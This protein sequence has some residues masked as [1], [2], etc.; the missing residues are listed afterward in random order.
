MRYLLL[1]VLAASLAAENAHTPTGDHNGD[2]HLDA[3]N[4]HL[5]ACASHA[6]DGYNQD[7]EKLGKDLAKRLKICRSEAENAGNTDAVIAIDHALDGLPKVDEPVVEAPTPAPAPQPE[8]PNPEP[9]LKP[10]FSKVG[11]K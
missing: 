11:A 3:G 6:I 2:G 4:S 10:D 5:P 7:V 9:K 1:I 8:Q